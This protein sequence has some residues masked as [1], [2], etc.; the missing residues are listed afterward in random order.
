VSFGLSANMRV[1]EGLRTLAAHRPDRTRAIEPLLE[2][3][4]SAF[5]TSCHGWALMN[6]GEAR[7]I[8][9]KTTAEVGDGERDVEALS[10]M[11]TRAMQFGLVE[12]TARALWAVGRHGRAL[13]DAFCASGR[14]TDAGTELLRALSLLTIAHTSKKART[15]AFRAIGAIAGAG[16]HKR[17]VAELRDL[18]GRDSEASVAMY[19]EVARE[20]LFQEWRHR[21]DLPVRVTSPDDI[22]L[23]V[24]RAACASSTRSWLEDQEQLLPVVLM[25]PWL[26]RAEARELFLPRRWASVLS[27]PYTVESGLALLASM[28]NAFGLRRPTTV[29]APIRVGRNERCP[30][31]RGPKYKRCCGVRSTYRPAV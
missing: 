23:D 28:R 26:A 27:Q 1:I 3:W 18:F 10:A 19:D 15:P 30:C 13:L 8:H 7:S 5:W 25:V 14:R 6:V 2:W 16:H 20:T 11:T 12:P 21:S 4:W 31:G 24:A 29:R 22:P 9:A 17:V